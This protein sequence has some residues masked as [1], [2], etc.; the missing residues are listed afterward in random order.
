[1]ICIHKRNKYELLCCIFTF[2]DTP[3]TTDGMRNRCRY[4]AS[5]FASL[6]QNTL[7][8]KYT[9]L[10]WLL[11]FSEPGHFLFLPEL[12]RFPPCVPTRADVILDLFNLKKQPVVSSFMYAQKRCARDDTTPLTAKMYLENT[13]K[14]RLLKIGRRCAVFLKKFDPTV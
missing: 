4:P 11:K 13:R 7:S 12:S 9:R 3:R 1:M 14:T 8:D 6:H 2:Y 5:F 10:F